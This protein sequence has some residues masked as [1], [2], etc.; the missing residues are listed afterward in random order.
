[1]VTLRHGALFCMTASVYVVIR[2][3]CASAVIPMRP[4]SAHGIASILQ[5]DAPTSIDRC[6]CSSYF[7]KQ[8][9]GVRAIS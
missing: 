7:S 5:K 1:M 6:I 9:E 3:W 4:P 8:L 2:D